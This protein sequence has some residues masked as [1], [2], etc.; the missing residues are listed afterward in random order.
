MHH[1]HGGSADR[2]TLEGSGGNAKLVITRDPNDFGIFF[3]YGSVIGMNTTDAYFSLSTIVYNPMTNTGAISDY[4]N[5]DYNLPSVPAYDGVAD[6]NITRNVSSSDYH[7]LINV[8]TGKGDPCRLIGMTADE[9]RGFPDDAALYAR[10]EALKAAGIGGWRLPTSIENQRFSGQHALITY[11]SHWW[12]DSGVNQS[13]FGNPPVAG[14]E[15]P[16]RGFGGSAKF[17]P[18]AG[19]RNNYGDLSIYG[20]YYWSSEAGVYNGGTS[21][22][23]SNNSI[24]PIKYEG[25]HIACP[26]RCVRDDQSGIT[27]SVEDWGSGGT[28]GTGGE[29]DIVL[30]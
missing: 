28:L 3:K 21:L 18:E 5:N 8:R 15:F 20:G 10:E 25:F 19:S 17:L 26:V 13:P 2:I 24:N 1:A 23:F 9:I 22:H 12:D 6:V 11:S 7:H 27:L 29:G 4:S 16:E 30:P 14:G